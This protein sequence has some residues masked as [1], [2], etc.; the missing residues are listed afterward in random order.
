MAKFH[1]KSSVTPS[2]SDNHEDVHEEVDNVQID[3]QSGKDV[4]LG[5][6]GVLVL[7]P[8]HQ[9][10][11]VDNVKREDEGAHRSISNHC[12]LCLGQESH[13]DP[14]DDENYQNSAEHTST[15]S[16]VNLSLESKDGQGEG[17]TSCDSDSNQYSIHI[18]EGG[19]GAQHDSFA[20]GE[21]TQE[22]EVCGELPPD[23]VTAG[24]GDE[25]DNH[26]S[27][28]G[29]VDPQVP[30]HII[31]YVFYK[32]EGCNNSPCQDQL[33]HQDAVHLSNKV[34]SDCLFPKSLHV[35]GFI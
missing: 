8:H 5:A 34:S 19:D 27:H 29:V 6:E 28:A 17:D 3:V 35:L 1:L 32:H 12:P 20:K 23:A 21:Y 15:D 11:V 24:H 18:I 13:N 7:A 10:C 9:L 26:D 22:D 16:E 14:S 31:F 25:A 4:L 30:L 33:A 2:S